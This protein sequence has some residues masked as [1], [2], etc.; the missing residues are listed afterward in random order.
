MKPRVA[1]TFPPIIILFCLVFAA[2]AQDSVPT[3]DQEL[4]NFHQVN[5]QLYRGAQPR[6]GGFKRLAQLGIKT[7]INLRAGDDTSHAE[8]REARGAGLRYFGL[9]FKRTGRPTDEQIARALSIIN[10]PENQ[11]VFVHCK[12]GEDRTGTV[13][14]IYRIVHDGW[15]SERAKAEANRIG[16]HPW[17]VGMKTYIHDYHQRHQK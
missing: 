5:S 12:L 13:V 4:P 11:P 2:V 17:E 6:R 15:T 8:E 7:V 9:P 10:D 1:R 16:M 14:A 3:A